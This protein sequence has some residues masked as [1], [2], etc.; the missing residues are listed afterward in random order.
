MSLEELLCQVRKIVRRTGANVHPTENP[1]RRQV[2][3]FAYWIEPYCDPNA[4]EYS[5]DWQMSVRQFKREAEDMLHPFSTLSVDK[6]LWV[7]ASSI[8]G[9]RIDKEDPKFSCP[10]CGMKSWLEDCEHSEDECIEI[11]M[12]A[13]HGS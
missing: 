7:F 2:G 6:M 5:Q 13:V 1:A 10:R 12:E 8:P 4:L 11:L 9:Q 3:L